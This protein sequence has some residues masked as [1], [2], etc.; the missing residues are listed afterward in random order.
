MN[1][2]NTDHF[3]LAATDKESKR[4]ATTFELA[5]VT[6]VA[7]SVIALSGFLI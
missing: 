4:S 3:L 5:S 1:I 6:V 7:I 2:N